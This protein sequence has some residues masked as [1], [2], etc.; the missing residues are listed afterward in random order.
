[1]KLKF[2]FFCLLFCAG[3]LFAQSSVISGTV[4]NSYNINETDFK[5]IFLKNN[6]KIDSC[7]T[8][9]SGIYRFKLNPGYY[10]IQVISKK[11]LPTTI[12][13]VF[14]KNGYNNL[15]LNLKLQSTP[16]KPIYKNLDG[17]T[18]SDVIKPSTSV[19]DGDYEGRT[20]SEEPMVLKSSSVATKSSTKII[21]SITSDKR[22]SDHKDPVVEEKLI[23]NTTPKAGMITAGHW[24]DLDHWNDW[25]KTNSEKE[26]SDIQ[27]KWKLFPNEKFELRFEDKKNQALAFTKVILFNSKNEIIGQTYTDYAGYAYFWHNLFS[28]INKDEQLSIKAVQGDAIFELKNI[29]SYFNSKKT[30]QTEFK[31]QNK[32][33]LE[34]GFVIDATGSMGDEIKYLQSELTNVIER[35]QKKNKCLNILTGSVFYK[36]FGDDYVTKF[37]PMSHNPAQTLQF[38]S[39]NNSGGGGDF[40]EAVDEAMSTAINDLQWSNSNNPRILFL[41]LDAPPHENENNL[42]K[43]KEY[44]K[45]AA[46]KG[47]QIIPI[48]ASGINKATEF[49]LKNM[50]II[51]NGEYIYITD[52][53]K[54]GNAHIKPTGG[55]SKVEFLNELMIKLIQKYSDADWCKSNDNINP[56][57]STNNQNQS[58]E[59]IAGKNWQM[60]FYPNPCREILNIEFSEKVE[61]LIIT[62]LNGKT[63]FETIN[64]SELNIKTEVGQWDSGVYVVYAVKSGETISGKL[65]VMH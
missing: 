60:T 6:L 25:L 21:G 26:I 42:N 20:H 16:I 3:K 49:L 1:M 9:K 39:D 45:L 37:M 53:S 18:K 4:K 30:I 51:T 34:I 43:M 56:I 57:D 23:E 64:P 48:A 22:K 8:D 46:E 7:I 14:I 33:Q 44:T 12:E 17:Y 27:K 41:L 28:Q 59:L 10:S 19:T 52:D 54:I 65:V 40:P 24:R 2:V 55:E 35:V 47:I 5:L 50:A 58:T 15:N 13:K 29:N 31:I 38:I 11:Y 62:D 36:D 61:K 32:A 63:I